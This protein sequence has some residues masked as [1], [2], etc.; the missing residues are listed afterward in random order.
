MKDSF[1]LST[2]LSGRSCNKSEGPALKRRHQCRA[3]LWLMG[4]RFYYSMDQKKMYIE[5]I[6]GKI[7]R[8]YSEIVNICQ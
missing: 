8:K 3:C 7:Y 1:E 5:C 6:N 4:G 2:H